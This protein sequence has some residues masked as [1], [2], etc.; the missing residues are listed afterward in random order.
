MPLEGTYGTEIQYGGLPGG[1]GDKKGKV[2][3]GGHKQ[4]IDSWENAQITTI[5]TKFKDLAVD[6]PLDVSIEWKPKG[7]KTTNIVDLPN[8]FTLRRPELMR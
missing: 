7:S 4:K 1:F 5:F 2:Y 6:T 8:A 3:I